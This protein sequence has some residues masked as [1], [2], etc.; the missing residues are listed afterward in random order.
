[1]KTRKKS[2]L[3]VC[4]VWL[5]ISVICL[6]VVNC[7]WSKYEPGIG[8]AT[9]WAVTKYGMI[10]EQCL[11]TG[12]AYGNSTQMY[13]QGT[14][15]Y[16]AQTFPL[17]VI[18][19]LENGRTV[20]WSTPQQGAIP[21]AVTLEY[22]EIEITNAMEEMHVNY[23][24]GDRNPQKSWVR[25]VP[26]SWGGVRNLSYHITKQTDINQEVSLLCFKEYRSS[27]ARISFPFV[28]I[29]AFIVDIIT[30]PLQFVFLIIFLISFAGFHPS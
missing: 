18:V 11:L 20:S 4:K 2:F 14:S 15:L 24:K 9:H 12:P 5:V 21:S 13:V 26:L 22:P 28:Y 25:P 7:F 17:Y 6:C 1:M 23:S 16:E 19:E 10:R 29:G 8:L 3:T 30:A 27:S